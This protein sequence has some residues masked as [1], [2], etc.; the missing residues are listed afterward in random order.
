[1]GGLWQTGS[2]T[3]ATRRYDGDGTTLDY[4][5]VGRH[6]V[7]EHVNHATVPHRAASAL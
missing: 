5:Q 6:Y 1:M 4:A 7:R 2:T 3:E